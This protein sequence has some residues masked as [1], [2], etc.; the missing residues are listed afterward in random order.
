M[1]FSFKLIKITM[2]FFSLVLLCFS[3]TSLVKAESEYNPPIISNVN[4]AMDPLPLG[5]R[6]NITAEVTDDSGI[7]FVNFN[8]Q[9]YS[10][11]MTNLVGN[12]YNI[13]LG[14]PYVGVYSYTINA[15][16]IFGNTASYS[17]EFSIIY[18]NGPT[19]NA[20]FTSPQVEFG[21]TALLNAYIN[22]TDGVTVAKLD[23]GGFNYTLTHTSGDLYTYNWNPTDIGVFEYKVWAQ[24]YWGNTNFISGN[25]IVIDADAPELYATDINPTT[26]NVGGV[27]SIRVG[28]QDI[29]Q[30][31][32]VSYVIGSTKYEM[33][34]GTGNDVGYWVST[35]IA[36]FP[37]AY[38]INLTAYDAPGNKLEV[39]IGTINV[40]QPNSQPTTSSSSTSSGSSSGTSTS[41]TSSSSN[42]QGTNTLPPAN[43]FNTIDG[44]NSLWIIGII[45]FT[46]MLLKKRINK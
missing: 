22:D 44:F 6:Q 9:G 13:S 16:D 4:E 36:Q 28:L 43:P 2:M 45:G 24:D 38:N 21:E 7:S 32:N 14:I 41:G 8:Y 10:Y 29:S 46:G 5:M 18:A 37:G 27:V 31:A 25:I 3:A 26:V 11:A 15:Q 40:N 12:T 20:S 19:I 23:I 42:S 34:R 33:I 39:M 35:W 1:K 30:I 17:G